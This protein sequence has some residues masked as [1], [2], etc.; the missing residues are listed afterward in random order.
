MT[1]SR[2]QPVVLVLLAVLGPVVA[3]RLRAPGAV[4]LAR[5]IDA[6]L[7]LGIV[8]LLVVCDRLRRWSR[9]G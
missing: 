1:P 5:P 9:D 7:V 4:S 8:A 2:P 3:Y 6:F